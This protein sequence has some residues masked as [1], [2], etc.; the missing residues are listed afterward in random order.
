[1]TRSWFRSRSPSVSPKRAGTAAAA[2]V[3]AFALLPWAESPLRRLAGGEGDGPDPVA[4]V[5]LD[6]A[7]FRGVGESHT[8]MTYFVDAF[9]ESPLVQGNLKAVGHL[10]FA[11]GLPVQD[12]A[13]ADYI[14][15]VRGT[16]IV[17]LRVR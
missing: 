17:H 7:S 11:L 16:R 12:R 3:L 14:V 1:M 10:Y 4:D 6:L 15:R 8:N 13:R 5:P 2:A 9:D